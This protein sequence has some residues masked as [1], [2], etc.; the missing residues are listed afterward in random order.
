MQSAWRIMK[1]FAD[2]PVGGHVGD[3]HGVL[4]AMPHTLDAITLDAM[5]AAWVGHPA[6]WRRP[7]AE[8]AA[9]RRL[10][11]SVA[12]AV[13]VV[14]NPITSPVILGVPG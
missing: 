6:I 14:A 11:T 10:A 4:S 1:L 7:T 3:Y 8:S 12:I 9:S 2:L 13:G 5:S